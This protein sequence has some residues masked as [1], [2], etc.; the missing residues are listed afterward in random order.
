MQTVTLVTVP[1]CAEE[2]VLD[3]A[4]CRQARRVNTYSVSDLRSNSTTPRSGDGKIRET[5]VPLKLQP[6]PRPS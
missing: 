6:Y 1:N 4:L 2:S 5:L 3:P